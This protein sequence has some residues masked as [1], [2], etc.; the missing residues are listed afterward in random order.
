MIEKKSGVFYGWAILAACFVMSSCWGIFYSYGIFLKPLVA[1]LGQSRG[2]IS[3]VFSI[4][5]IISGISGIFMGRLTDKY[6]TRFP[7]LLSGF[8]ITFGFLLCSQ[9]HAVWQL[10]LF[11]GITSAGAGVIFSLPPAT[12]QRWFIKKRGLALG[13]MTAG[14]GIGTLILAPLITRLISLYDWR[15][16]FAIIGIVTFTI[17]LISALV[18][19]RK[20]EEKGLRPYGEDEEN[21]SRKIEVVKE[22]NGWNTR[23]S[24][25]TKA[26]WLTNAV[27]FFSILPTYLVTIHIASFATDIGFSE[28]TAA[29]ILGLIFGISIPGRIAG[30]FFAERIGWGKGIFVCCIICASMLIWLTTIRGPELYLFAIIYGLFFGARVPMIPG[31][32]GSLFGTRFLTEILGTINISAFVGGAIGSSLG[33]FIFDYTGSYYAAFLAGALSWA[34][35]GIL[36]LLVKSPQKLSQGF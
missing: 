17:F 16:T 22:E 21:I 1:D 6:G 10:Y 26:F 3:S 31:L 20:P 8:L 30:G 18:V 29:L 14:T 32:A 12:V 11:Y 2:V 33:G 23:E 35:A 4:F 25:Q 9:I 28:A 5:M 15:A 24:V 27:Y 19:V 13:I 34:I 7:L 36:S